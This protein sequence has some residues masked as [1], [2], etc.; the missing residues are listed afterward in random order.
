MELF[1]E[2]AA[3][4]GKFTLESR[5]GEC[6]K[7]SGR[8]VRRRTYIS[9]ARRETASLHEKLGEENC[10]SEENRQSKN[11]GTEGGSYCVCVLCEGYG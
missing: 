1:A 8:G 7:E 10:G 9:E 6:T 2:T 5:W 4:R 3:Q 11:G